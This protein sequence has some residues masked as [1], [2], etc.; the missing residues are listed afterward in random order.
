M[1]T[2]IPLDRYIGDVNVVVLER[3][4]PKFDT[5]LC[6]ERSSVLSNDNDAIKDHKPADTVTDILEDE[7][8]VGTT[9]INI[10]D[11]TPRQV[12]LVRSKT[13]NDIKTNQ[14]GQCF[15]AHNVLPNVGA[16]S[17]KEVLTEQCLNGIDRRIL[18]S[19]EEASRTSEEVN[20]IQK[21]ETGNK[22]LN[23][24]YDKEVDIKK[25]FSEQEILDIRSAVK[26][27][28]NI[29]AETIGELDSRFRLQE[30]IPVGSAREGTQIVRPCEY[31]YILIV[32]ALSKLGAVSLNC[33]KDDLQ[34]MPV[35]PEDNE[36]KFLFRECIHKVDFKATGQL[37]KIKLRK[38]LRATVFHAVTLCSKVSVSKNTG[39]LTC[40]RSKP[41][42]HGPADTVMFEW[43]RRIKETFM[44]MKISVDLVLALK[45]DWEVY[46]NILESVHHDV[47][48][49]FNP[50]IQSVGSVLFIM[51]KRFVVR[52]KVAFTEAELLY[53]A[54]LSEHHRK[55]YKLL[56][57]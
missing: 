23:E 30:V 35:T 24:L 45:I 18:I 20:D 40:K 53:T 8:V 27:Q 32:E 19:L 50:H 54:E 57:M 33:H 11:A 21:G 7:K 9:Y 13:D 6:D 55:C 16:S 31:D 34:Y 42:A 15:D 44:P 51:P 49:D 36:V 2:R 1:T 41:V 56:N 38:R 25:N 43:Q 46:N 5:S 37:S 14:D 48:P 39:S 22:F 4:K 12:N 52:F 10:E 47:S 28:L 3:N 29:L 26:Q 17:M